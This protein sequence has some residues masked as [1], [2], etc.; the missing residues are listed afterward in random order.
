MRRHGTG[1]LELLFLLAISVM[2]VRVAT[3]RLHHAAPVSMHDEVDVRLM[4][5]DLLQAQNRARFS[6]KATQ[7][8]L[9]IDETG[10]VVAYTVQWDASPRGVVSRPPIER[11]IAQ[12]YHVTSDTT[13]IAFDAQGRA[14]GDCEIRFIDDDGESWQLR[15]VAEANS[16]CLHRIVE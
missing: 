16:I 12:R 8:V 7:V 15:I 13:R 3:G 6:G 5:V 9:R 2:L 11:T 4:A 14:Q 1:L 10:Q